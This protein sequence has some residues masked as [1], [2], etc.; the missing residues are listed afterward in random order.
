MNI[1]D[2]NVKEIKVTRAVQNLFGPVGNVDSEQNFI[3]KRG[4]PSPLPVMLTEGKYYLVGE[5]AWMQ[6]LRNLKWTETIP[7][8]VVEPAA[9][10]NIHYVILASLRKPV[11]EVVIDK[12]GRVIGGMCYVVHSLTDALTE[13]ERPTNIDVGIDLKLKADPISA[14]RNLYYDEPEVVCRVANGEMGISVYSRIKAVPLSTRLA[15]VRSKTGKIS[16][17]HV[18]KFLRG[19]IRTDPLTV[20]EGDT[21]L[22]KVKDVFSLWSQNG[23]ETAVPG[24]TPHLRKALDCLRRVDAS[25][26]SDIDYDLADQIRVEIENVL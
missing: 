1:V 15:L 25:T 21:V 13:E 26:M 24:N 6:A 8:R 20:T 22:V 18:D 14:Y 10:I 4:L 12:K 5:F 3:T 16:R 9:N 19:E 11:P 7:C 17:R 23:G 2:L